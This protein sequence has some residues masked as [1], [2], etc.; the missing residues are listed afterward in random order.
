MDVFWAAFGGGAA[1]G[2]VGIVG[3]IVVEWMRVTREGAKLQV[4]ATFVLMSGGGVDDYQLYFAIKVSNPRM[5][6][7]TVDSYSLSRGKHG[8]LVMPLEYADP[9]LPQELAPGSS[10]GMRAPV[11]TLVRALVKDDLLV[12]DI[13]GVQVTTASGGVFTAKIHKGMRKKLEELLDE[14]REPV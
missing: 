3:I 1:A 8:T 4:G 10:A 9:Q 6:P 13:K 12:S 5:I 7:I 11:D 14:A 2:I